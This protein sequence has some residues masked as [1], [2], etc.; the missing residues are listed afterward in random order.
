ME[1]LGANRNDSTKEYC[2][3]TIIFVVF[4]V[5]KNL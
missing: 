1:T 2:E 4:P 3:K 5:Y